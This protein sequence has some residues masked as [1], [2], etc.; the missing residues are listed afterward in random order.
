[1]YLNTILA[2]SLAAVRNYHYVNVIHDTYLLTI[3]CIK[4]C[5]F[6]VFNYLIFSNQTLETSNLCSVIYEFFKSETCITN[7]I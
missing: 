4:S 5:C 3:N 6:L 1:M 7:A 2:L